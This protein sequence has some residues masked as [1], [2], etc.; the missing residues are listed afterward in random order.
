MGRLL[1]DGS[2]AFTGRKDFQVKIRGVRIEPGEIEATLSQHPGVRECVVLARDDV[3]GDK[4]LVA[5]IVPNQQPAPSTDNLRSFLKKKLPD[6][7]VPSAF[8][9]LEALPL[10]PNG[11]VDRKALPAPI[12]V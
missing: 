2:I 4:R 11:K 12:K 10:T 5:Y 1:S 7:M 9:Y 8:V 6:Y 3:L